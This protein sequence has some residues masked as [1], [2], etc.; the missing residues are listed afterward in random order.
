MGTTLAIQV[1]DLHRSFGQNQAVDG[2]SFDVLR[3]EIF[4]LLGPTTP[5]SLIIDAYENV[6][7]R[8]LGVSSVLMSCALLLACATGLAV[9]AVLRF[10]RQSA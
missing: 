2:V 4:S 8:G 7:Q 6:V 10:R 1:Q 3:G 9:L 5:G